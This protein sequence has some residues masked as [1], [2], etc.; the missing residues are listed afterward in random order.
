MAST[1]SLILLE[2]RREL[3]RIRSYRANLIGDQVFFILSFLLVTGLFE[4]TT[5]GKYSHEAALASL[6]GWLT[7]RVAGGCMLEVS[8]AVAEEAQAGTLEQLWLSGASPAHILLARCVALVVYYTAR[9]TVMAVIIMP[10]LRLSLQTGSGAWLAAP[11]VYLLTLSGAFGVTF[12]IA[13]LHLAFKNVEAITYALATVLLFLTG[14]IVSFSDVPILYALSRFLPLSIGIDLLRSVLVESR[15]GW[16]IFTSWAF[17]SLLVN[18]LCY[19]LIGLITL[20]W[21]QRKALWTGSLAH[22]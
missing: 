8:D 6:I 17:I 13:G 11:L 3:Q 21:A 16:V 9:V 15:S 5:E 20:N 18:S 1:L 2:L 14:A 7:W 10:F 22:Y 19:L 4:V 12:T